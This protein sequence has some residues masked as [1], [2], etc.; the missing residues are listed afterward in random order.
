MQQ[1]EWIVGGQNVQGWHGS[2]LPD[3]DIPRVLAVRLVKITPEVAATY[4][5]TMAKNRTIKLRHVRDL[6]DMLRQGEWQLNGETIKF[7]ANGHLVDGQHRLHA[8]VQTKITVYSLVVFGLDPAVFG[9]I[10]IGKVRSFGD[11]AGHLGYE[12]ANT[13]GGALNTLYTILHGEGAVRQVRVLPKPFLLEY[14]KAHPTMVDSVQK[15]VSMRNLAPGSALGACHYL[16]AVVDQEAADQFFAQLRQGANLEAGSPILALSKRLIEGRLAKRRYTPF[17]LAAYILK[18]WNAE[19]KG[20]QVRVLM[21]RTTG[22]NPESFPEIN[23]LPKH[24]ADEDLRLPP[25][26]VSTVLLK[27]HTPQGIPPWLQR[28]GSKT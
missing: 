21:W 20:Q 18:A 22:Q 4:L 6:V 5:A 28:Q 7:D 12:N 9:T 17:E 10:D 1:Q 14:L 23:G 3:V 11:L 8:I 2:A 27:E 25:S 24:F 15:T 26:T 16:C 19:R 13:L